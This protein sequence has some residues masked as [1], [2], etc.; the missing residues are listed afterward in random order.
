MFENI[1]SYAHFVIESFI[2]NKWEMMN[3]KSEI[4]KKLKYVFQNVL[5]YE[6]SWLIVDLNEIKS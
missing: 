5:S 3:S 4:N 1:Q 2:F 6:H